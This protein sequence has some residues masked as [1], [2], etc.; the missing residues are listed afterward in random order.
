MVSK[1]HMDGWGTVLMG[2]A[3]MG[4]NLE[5]RHDQLCKRLEGIGN[6]V[7]WTCVLEADAQVRSGLAPE[8]ARLLRQAEKDFERATKNGNLTAAEGAAR[9]GLAVGCAQT[10]TTSHHL[11]RLSY[12]ATT[13]LATAAAPTAAATARAGVMAEEAATAHMARVGAA[14]VA[15][16]APAAAAAAGQL[17][18]RRRR[19]RTRYRRVWVR[20]R[21]D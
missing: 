16:V 1:G 8:Q 14:A 9:R 2:K 19:R 21:V 15:T 7:G 10:I 17:A 11:I 3:F 13:A 12:T 4:A 5:W 6:A 20:Q 18:T